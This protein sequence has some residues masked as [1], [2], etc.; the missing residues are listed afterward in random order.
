MAECGLHDMGF[1]G[2]QFTWEKF[3]G[4]D[5]W[6][7]E[8]LDRGLATQTWINIFPAAI[9]K[10]I[11]VSTSDHFP[12]LLE[13]NK[14]VYVPKCK[15]FQFD[16]MWVREKD[17]YNLVKECWDSEVCGDIVNK[18]NRCCLRLEEWGGGLVKEMKEQLALMRVQMRRFR[19][20]RDDQGVRQY[21][22]ARWE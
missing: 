6:V 14:K 16:N 15:R 9:V 12:L 13:L 2:E 22:T 1:Q 4:T 3:R 5:K 18:I 17:C 20:R 11:D 10:V 8:R 7:Q 19:S 21:N